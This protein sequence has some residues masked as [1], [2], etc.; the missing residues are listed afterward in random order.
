MDKDA[1]FEVAFKLVLFC[2]L[3]AVI[4]GIFVGASSAIK[5]LDM[6]YDKHKEKLWNNGYCPECNVRYEYV[7]SITEKS[8]FFF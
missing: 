8:L 5:G 6:L 2:G 3:I 7:E 1:V 4:V